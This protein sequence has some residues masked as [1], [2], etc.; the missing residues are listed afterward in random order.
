MTTSYDEQPT[1][2]ERIRASQLIVIGR[3]ESIELLRRE[4]VGEVDE[5][6]A[7]AHVV[8]EAVMR[9][10]QKA[11]RLGVRF[12]LPADRRARA[13]THPFRGGQRL[14]L[15]LVSDAGRDARPNTFVAYLRGHYVLSDAD[16]FLHDAT[17]LSLRALRDSIRSVAAAETAEDRA[18]TKYESALRNRR[19][20]PPI[21]EVP[22]PQFGAG[23]APDRPAAAGRAFSAQ[24]QRGARRR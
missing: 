12:I 22:E 1:L 6:Q 3:V 21:T 18:W 16:T 13:R 10:V 9:G 23:P 8:V 4:R 5:Q 7:I 17:R 19:E 2:E 24:R 11:R 15:F 20:L 14:A